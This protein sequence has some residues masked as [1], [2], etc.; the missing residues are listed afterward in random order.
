M[1][2]SESAVS[3]SAYPYIWGI[4]KY[5]YILYV[6]YVIFP[7]IRACIYGFSKASMV[8]AVSRASLAAIQSS[9]HFGFELTKLEETLE[10]QSNHSL[11]RARLWGAYLQNKLSTKLTCLEVCLKSCT[12]PSQGFSRGASQGITRLDFKQLCDAFG[13]DR[14][15]VGLLC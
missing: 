13:A 5:V 10:T 1:V 14:A 2:W 6:P 12:K 4:H 9:Q 8:N 11:C 15:S 3:T 7:D